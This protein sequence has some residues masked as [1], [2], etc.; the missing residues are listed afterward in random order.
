VNHI[1]YFKYP[2]TYHLP[3]SL[4][5]TND[6]KVLNNIDHFIGKNI[7]VTEKLDGENTNM[8]P[9]YIH[10]RSLTSSDH[11]SQHWVKR[12]HSLVKYYIP[13]GWR[14]CGENL[15]AK[16]SIFYDRLESYFYAFSIWNDNKCLSWDDTEEWSAMLNLKTVPVLY[17]GIWD[18]D[19][20]K[21]CYTGKSQVG[22]IQ[23][24]YVVR[25]ADS[26]H[27]EEFDKCVGKFVR[28]KH[29]Q[30]NEHWKFGEIMPNKLI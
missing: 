12:F 23:E 8:Y 19:K 24:G 29:V 27:Y 3:W 4:G 9:D 13:E 7:I 6:D 14:I 25:I 26:F 1:N 10:A 17:K 11:V 28:E 16:H 5:A 22:D 2:R 20:V 18:E 21:Q 15:F 30:T